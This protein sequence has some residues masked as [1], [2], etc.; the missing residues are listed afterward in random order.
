M[1][2]ELND[3]EENWLQGVADMR[4]VKESPTSSAVH[5]DSL[6]GNQGRSPRKRKRK[7]EGLVDAIESLEKAENVPTDKELYA[8]VKAEAKKKFDVYPSAYANAWLVRE[9]KSRGGKY[10]VQ[11]LEK[12]AAQRIVEIKVEMRKASFASRSEAGRYAANQR[13]KNNT[14]E[15]MAPSEAVKGNSGREIDMNRVALLGKQDQ[16]D[17]MREMATSP[18]DFGRRVDRF[19]DVQAERGINLTTKRHKNETSDGR[20]VVPSKLHEDDRMSIEDTSTP[21][22]RQQRIDEIASSGFYAGKNIFWSPP[23]KK[24][25]ELERLGIISRA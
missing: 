21:D 15:D 7:K 20:R 22:E 1:I 6:M 3:D 23:R 12:Q 2:Y 4:M 10:R 18:E 25:N 19:I 8:R 16:I 11:S 5:V 13:W 9:Y 24:V 14:K 17:G